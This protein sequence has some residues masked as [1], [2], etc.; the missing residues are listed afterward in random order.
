MSIAQGSIVSNQNFFFTSHILYGTT[1]K[2]V[3]VT[4]GS[5]LFQ[6]GATYTNAWTLPSLITGITLDTSNSGF[7]HTGADPDVI[8]TATTTVAH[9]DAACGAGTGLGG[10]AF[11][12]GQSSIANAL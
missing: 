10:V 7:C 12:F 6:T 3:T 5:R 1:G 8:H 2:T 4:S 9:L 11:N